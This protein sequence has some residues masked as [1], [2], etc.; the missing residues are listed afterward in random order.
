LLVNRA[1]S[2]GWAG[3]DDLRAALGADGCMLASLPSLAREH[4]NALQA[5]ASRELD[6]KAA[7]HEVHATGGLRTTSIRDWR[8][9]VRLHVRQ[10]A[11]AFEPTEA[12]GRALDALFKA[13]GTAAG[14]AHAVVPGATIGEAALLQQTQRSTEQEP[15]QD[16]LDQFLAAIVNVGEHDAASTQVLKWPPVG[17]LRKAG[18]LSEG[19]RD[20]LKAMWQHV[21]SGKARYSWTPTRS[22]SATPPP[23]TRLSD[24]STPSSTTR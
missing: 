17:L 6:R 4:L 23:S 3:G 16:G 22:W 24:T 12:E 14:G 21:E 18:K 8:K 15:H 2:S 1:Y 13:L 20:R 11:A 5:M 19:Q 9:P 10:G 7:T